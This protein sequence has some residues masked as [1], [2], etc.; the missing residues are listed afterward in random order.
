MFRLKWVAGTTVSRCY[1]CNGEITNPPI[2]IPDDLVVVYR[3]I[4]QFRERETGQLRLT[5]APQNVHFHLRANCIRAR[6]QNFPGA[7]ALF[8]PQEFRRYFHHEHIL[9][10]NAEFGWTP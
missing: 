10:L 4:R 1:G 2:S 8:V 3:D 9:R 6:Y 5:T 7:S